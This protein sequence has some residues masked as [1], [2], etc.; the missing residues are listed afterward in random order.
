MA[1]SQAVKD[2]FVEIDNETTRIFGVVTGLLQQLSQNADANDAELIALAQ[3]EIDK[4][5]PIGATI[6]LG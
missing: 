2:K 3:T 4:L 5:K 6:P 1:V